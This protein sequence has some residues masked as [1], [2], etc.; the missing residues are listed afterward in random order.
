MKSDTKT[1]RAEWEQDVRPQYD[2]T[3]LPDA[4]TVA[5]V[6][7][8]LGAVEAGSPPQDPPAQRIHELAQ[9]ITN[10][11]ANTVMC[12][13]HG[14]SGERAPIDAQVE[15]LLREAEA[16]SSSNTENLAEL[17]GPRGDLSTALATALHQA[18]S[19]SAGSHEVV[20]AIKGALDA[21]R[22][23]RRAVEGTAPDKPCASFAESEARDECKHC[24]WTEEAHGA[25]PAPPPP[26]L[27][28]AL[29]AILNVAQ[30]MT[31]WGDSELDVWCR[32]LQ[33]SAELARGASAP[34]PEG[35][36]RIYADEGGDCCV[37]DTRHPDEIHCFT[38]HAEAITVRDALNGTVR[39]VGSPQPAPK[40]AS[41]G[42]SGIQMED[43]GMGRQEALGCPE[44]EGTGAAPQPPREDN[45]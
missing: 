37:Q 20:T 40:C 36:W 5:F 24:G 32:Q 19:R 38:T 21:M 2:L 23:L 13:E 9:Q 39:G 43:H 15:A 28:V 42:G 26:G 22:T 45:A 1:L 11:V 34:T 29:H 17:L 14:Y 8:L 10:L 27:R 33:M 4:I 7:R 12:P 41:C 35:P 6:E 16:P 44:C 25:A 31:S 18:R 30:Q 3:R